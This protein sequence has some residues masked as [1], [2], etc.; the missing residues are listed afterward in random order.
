MAK[1]QKQFM[2]KLKLARSRINKLHDNVWNAGCKYAQLV[3]LPQALQE[4]S[5]LTQDEQVCAQEID[6]QAELFI[7]SLRA[8]EDIV[9]DWKTAIKD[10]AD[11]VN[12]DHGLDW[13]AG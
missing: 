9:K 1:R 12:P 10:L 5:N 2:K 3:T 13:L 4:I 6:K 8:V 11:K 7:E